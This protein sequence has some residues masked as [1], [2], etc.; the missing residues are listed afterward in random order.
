MRTLTFDP[1]ER[2]Y[3]ADQA[4]PAVSPRPLPPARRRPPGPWRRHLGKLLSGSAIV[5]VLLGGGLWLDMSGRL[6]AMHSGATLAMNQLFA[7]AGLSVQQITV[8]GRRG[9]PSDALLAAVGVG[10]GD[11]IL[12]LD[13]EAA[14]KR[15]EALGWVQSATVSRELPD[16][17]HVALLEREPFARWQIDGKTT[18]IDRSGTVLQTEDPDAFGELRRVVGAGAADK[19]S[20]L[21]NLLA[22]EPALAGRVS[23]AIRVRNRRWDIEFDNGITA[24][25]PEVEAASAWRYLGEVERDQHI[26]NRDIS[27]IDLRLPDRMVVRLTPEAMSGRKTPGKNT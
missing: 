3:R 18:L 14:R 16:T 15:V 9:T 27:M 2:P 23:N 5:L 22:S 24:R 6:E 17:V 13:L 10:R 21:F 11:P 26:L 12:L 8:E 7:I 4:R 19:A 1:R 25:L 20:E